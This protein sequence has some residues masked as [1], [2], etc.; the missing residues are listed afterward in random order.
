M[1]KNR[2]KTSCPKCGHTFSIHN[3]REYQIKAKYAPFWF[4]EAMNQFEYFN[5]VKCPFCKHTYKAAE[6]RLFFIF[7]SPYTVVISG[8]LFLLAAILLTVKLK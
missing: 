7:R 8:L 2:E 1:K 4:I 3:N 5:E 6:A